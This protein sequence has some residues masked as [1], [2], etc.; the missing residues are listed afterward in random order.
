MRKLST[1]FIFFFLIIFKIS[2]II[3]AKV[4]ISIGPNTSLDIVDIA[5]PS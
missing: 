4:P 1:L 2:F 3:N 5:K